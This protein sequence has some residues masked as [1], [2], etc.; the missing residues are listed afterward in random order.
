MSKHSIGPWHAAPISEKTWNVGI[1]NEAGSLL[2]TIKVASKREADFRDAD[3]RLMA[4]APT[5]LALLKDS[6]F[7]GSDWLERRAALFLQLQGVLS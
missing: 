2:A 1:Y 3:A 6:E 5:L 7:M 4:A